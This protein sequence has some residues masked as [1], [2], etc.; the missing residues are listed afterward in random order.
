MTVAQK[1]NM[2]TLQMFLLMVSRSSQYVFLTKVSSGMSD[3]QYGIISLFLVLGSL[4]FA[5]NTLQH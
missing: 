5:Q 1:V 2:A 3:I 4:C